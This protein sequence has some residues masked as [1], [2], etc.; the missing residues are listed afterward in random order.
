LLSELG[1]CTACDVETQIKSSH[2]RPIPD[3]VLMPDTAND[4][5][6][7]RIHAFRNV[8]QNLIGDLICRG[9]VPGSMLSY[10]NLP[11]RAVPPAA[12]ARN[13]RSERS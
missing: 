13:V 1:S 10:G 9:A 7:A 5:R 11:K 4:L 8:K 12:H 6:G 3:I 2:R